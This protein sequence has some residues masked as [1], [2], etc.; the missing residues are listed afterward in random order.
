M[1]SENSA[2]IS[3]VESFLSELSRS[4]IV[5]ALVFCVCLISTFELLC[6]AERKIFFNAFVQRFFT[7]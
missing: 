7:P 2:A 5:L 3:K 4:S 1:A 6:S